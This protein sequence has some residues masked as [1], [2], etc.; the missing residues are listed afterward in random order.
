MSLRLLMILVTVATL[1]RNPSNA[2]ELAGVHIVPHRID[3]ELQYRKPHD[4]NLAARVQLF[5]QGPASTPKFE[6][7]QPSELVEKGEWA[8]H[9]LNAA[10]PIPEGAIGVW[11]FNGR[12]NRWAVG[13]SFRLEAEGLAPVLIEIKEPR[14]WISSIT[15]LRKADDSASPI[16]DTM[17]VYVANGDDKPIQI[18][19][20]KIWAPKDN[21]T[22]QIL[23]PQASIPSDVRVEPA[24]KRGIAVRIQDLPL[25]YAAIQVSTSAGEL[26]AHVRVKREQ[27]D[28]SGG[29]VFDSK[30]K[31]QE[32][33]V[34]EAESGKV[35]SNDFLDLLSSMHVNT[36]H[37]ERTSGY[38]DT[39]ELVARNPLKRFHRLWPTEEWE[40]ESLLPTIH[41]V[42]FLGEPQYGGGKPVAPQA[43]FDAL[44][45]YRSSKLPTSVTHS[46][47]RIWRFYAGLSDYPHFDAYRVVAPAA[48]AW[49]QYDRWNGEKI[50]WAAP[51]ETI[52]NLCRSQ[53]ELN[54]PMPCA[55]W[56]Q[57]PHHDWGS[58]FRFGKSRQRRSPNPDE[59]R[60]QAL[61]ALATRVTSLYWFNLSKQALDM[62]PDTCDTMR[63]IGREIRVL[64]N[65][66]LEGDAYRFTRMLDSES[67]PNW[68]L[69]SIV[70]PEA[71]LLFALDTAYSIDAEKMEFSFGPARNA[72]FQFDLPNWL[73]RPI[74]VFR[75]DADGIYEADWKF[76]DGRLVIHENAS[77]DRIYVASTNGQL[78]KDLERR[79]QQ[80]IDRE[81]LYLKN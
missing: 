21:S 66:Y 70:A 12:T 38:S 46:E 35:T 45:P 73:A 74:D 32:T 54:R 47:E 8:W 10:V 49:R 55:V 41:A 72:T 43:V 65:L 36:A 29:W 34:R 11:S 31:W 75:I 53:R 67:R 37:Y 20:V 58:G 18:N 33:N 4:D 17:M 61:H 44:L 15:F 30:G 9:D 71:A 25:S 76:I 79:R 78:R 81:S 57:G 50:S 1:L 19:S 14:H 56:S 51:L 59:L 6:Q 80:A 39:P 62:F 77:R 24:E 26:W 16:P 7:Q 13:N 40:K 23:W 60:A 28:I 64:E 63:R 5:I 2:G 69:S 27:F 52:G 68:E 3:T 22:W 48:D 42:E